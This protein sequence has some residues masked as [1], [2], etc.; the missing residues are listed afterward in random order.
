MTPDKI[1]N[2]TIE[3]IDCT[4]TWLSLLPMMLEL[5]PDIEKKYMR[6]C[7]KEI[8]DSYNGLRENFKRMAIAADKWNE[9]VKQKNTEA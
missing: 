7:S 8:E 5:Y 4:P 1:E 2:V 6:N 9:Y 3:T